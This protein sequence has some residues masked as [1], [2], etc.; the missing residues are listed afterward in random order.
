[1]EG[2]QKTTS[3]T[4][5]NINLVNAVANSCLV[6]FRNNVTVRFLLD[7][8]A[9]LSLLRQ[10]IFERIG[11]DNALKPTSVKLQTANGNLLEV[12][13][14]AEL[15]FKIGSVEQTHAFY[16][17]NNLNRC[18]LLG[19]DWM[20][21][22]QIRIYF[23]LQKMRVGGTLINLENDIHI[24]SILRT[25]GDTILQANTIH[26]IKGHLKGNPYFS[27]KQVYETE[28]PKGGDLENDPNV[29]INHAAVT[30]NEDN[31]VPIIIENHGD[32]DIFLRKGT[33]IA[34]LQYIH[35]LNEVR[36][37]GIEVDKNR[38]DFETNMQRDLCCNENFR[39]QVEALLR[40]NSDSFAFSD[41]EITKT[42]TIT[43]DIKTTG[44]PVNTRPYRTPLHDKAKL[45][46]VINTLVKNN[47][48]EGNVRSQ[49]NSPIMLLRKKGE[50]ANSSDSHRF[51]IDLRNVNKVVQT[52]IYRMP[53][54][55]DVLSRLYNKPYISTLDIKSGFFAI[56]LT[57]EAKDKTA[58][59][60][61]MGS[62]RFLCAP[63]GL[64]QSPFEY[65]RLMDIVLR[66][67]H[68]HVEVYMDD[69]IVFSD[70]LEMHWQHLQTVFDR[71]RQHNL[72]MK[73]KKCSFLK[74]ETK[75]LGYVVTKD[76][77][78]P[79]REKVAVIEAL[80]NPTNPKSAKQALGF[81]GW[82]RKYL[83]D[84][85]KLTEPLIELTKK[86]S[87]FHWNSACQAAYDQLKRN[88]AALPMLYHPQLNK[89]MHLFTDVSTGSATTAG[90]I[91]CCLSQS[92]ESEG[93]EN[94]FPHFRNERPL[95]FISTKLS[96]TQM[97]YSIFELET[98]AV[99][100]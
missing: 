61:H 89:P 22:K 31:T 16:I 4:T 27:S 19:L 100:F 28:P 60:C 26:L 62:F 13:G 7:S 95:Y 38:R 32:R 50:S 15:P 52:P 76:G 63:Q 10:D 14:L 39:P 9:D 69:V 25:K 20:R 78:K 17:V 92:D 75:F 73:L 64:K 67:L 74:T 48:I 57:E 21:Q 87:H 6:K 96:R 43:M 88:L 98:M 5:S 70:S 77:V 23:D 24:A 59:T 97:N 3:S 51:I 30:L 47:I 72:K 8:G 55:E 85:S 83:K 45:E 37:R 82:Y 68:N 71:L 54:V 93:P 84:F 44:P 29:I 99:D 53:L 40:K 86:R 80:P 2:G 1:M 12:K 11:T 79:D 65:M 35:E 34:Q 91:G 94:D 58:F 81:F 46:E 18:G 90:H 33:P 66:G 42:N 56:P 36:E 41:L 49:W